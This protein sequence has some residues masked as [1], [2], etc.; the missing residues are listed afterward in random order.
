MD[1]ISKEKNV[2][3]NKWIKIRKRNGIKSC[4]LIMF[5]QKL[6]ISVKNFLILIINKEY[7]CK[8][9]FDQYFK[10]L[11]TNPFYLFNNILFIYNS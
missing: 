1:N 11:S 9:L 4:K 10:F 6:F 7:C 3:Y 8:I 5:L 2:S